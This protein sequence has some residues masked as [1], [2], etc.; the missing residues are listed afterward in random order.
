MQTFSRLFPKHL[1]KRMKEYRDKYEHHLLL[2]MA[3]TGIEDARCFLKSIFP[4]MHGDF[5]ECTDEETEKAFLHRFVTAGAAVRYRAIHRRQV[6]DIVALDVALKRNDPE[7]FESLPDYIAKP[8]RHRLHYGHFFCHV[9]HQ[10]YIV[11]KGHNTRE[12]EH[13]MLRLLDARGA[14]YPAEHNVGHLY[15]AKP[16]LI[17]HYK[18]L[19][20]CNCFNPGI[21]RT[22]KHLRWQP[23]APAER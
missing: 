20:P 18:S 19:D 3:G 13:R 5:F 8:I 14:Q 9:F 1:P 12:L 10:D 16:A 11:C 15:E 22:S 21:G 7:W 2:K 17:N 4:S 6:E 23:A